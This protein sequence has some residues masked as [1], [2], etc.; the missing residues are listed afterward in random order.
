MDSFMVVFYSK[1]RFVKDP[2]I[3]YEGG[4]VY[5][6]NGQDPDYWSFFEARDL[7]K[8]IE[9]E[10]DIVSVKMWW[11]HE[12]GSFEHDLKPFKDDGDASEL[13]MYVIGNK[14]DIEIFCEPK[15]V[16]EDT[17]MDRFRERGK[18]TKC[19]EDVNRLVEDNDDSSDEFVRIVHFD[20]SE[21]ERMKGFVEGLDEVFDNAAKVEQKMKLLQMKRVLLI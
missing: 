19:D 11:K 5:A 7:I 15:F 17:F 13:A 10:F 21:E 18:G 12:E 14:S 20:D 9:P 3:R 16:G 6:F 4:D 8:L 1:G 2:K